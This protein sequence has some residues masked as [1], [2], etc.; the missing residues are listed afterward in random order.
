MADTLFA[1]VSEHQPPLDESYPYPWLSIRSND[2]TYRDHNFRENWDTARRM[3]DSGKLVGLI[4]YAVVRPNWEDSLAVHLDMQGENRP[5]VVSMADAESWSG[6][7]VGDHSH[8]FNSWVWG[9]SD[10]RGGAIDGRPRRAIGYLNP[11]DHSIWPD[12]PPIG[13]VVP[14]YGAAPR[15]DLPGVDLSDL[16]Q[17]MFAHQYTDGQGYGGGLPEGAPPFGNCD[18]NAA[19]GF[20]PEEL[21]AHLGVGD[22]PQEDD[23][24]GFTDEDRRKLD[25]IYDQLGP[26]HPEWSADSSLGQNAKGEEL[27]LR[28]GIASL[29]RRVAGK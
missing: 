1:D 29:I 10:W 13:F 16:Q 4:V 21:A 25:Y 14:S 7:I 28:D 18:M 19:N 9:V 3:L 8:E 24:A 15:F 20:S 17:Q 23:M 12:R 26:K 6:Q 2:G 11:N 22:A 5:D 27:T